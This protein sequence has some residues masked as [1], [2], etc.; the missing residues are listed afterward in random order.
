MQSLAL[1]Y[2]DRKT[3]VIERT[4]SI[5]F[6]QAKNIMEDEKART[7]YNKYGIEK[8]EDCLISNMDS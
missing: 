6:S 3:T 4:Y 2:F 8:A 7:I 5:T 1:R